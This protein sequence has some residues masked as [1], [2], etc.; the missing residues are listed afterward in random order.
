M[1]SS[2]L[3]WD[4]IAKRYSK[5]PVSNKQAYERKLEITKS[6]FTPESEILEFACGTGSTAITHAPFVKHIKAIDISKNMLDIAR[7]KA[8][9]AHIDNITFEQMTIDEFSEREESYDMVMA[10]SILHLLPNKAHAIKKAYNLLKPD[11]VFVSS[12][13]CGRGKMKLLRPILALG[14][15]V[16]LLPKVSFFSPESLQMS[17]KDAGFRLD[18]VWQPENSDSMFIVARKPAGQQIN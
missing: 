7:Q 18:H 17:V 8:N 2:V 6:Y 13:L 14:A 9:D 16:G 10:H 3:F 1:A 11:G 12:T 15:M 4:R 5:S